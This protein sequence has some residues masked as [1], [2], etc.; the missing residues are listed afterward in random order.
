MTAHDTAEGAHPVLL[1][2]K[3]LER[4]A[5]VVGAYALDAPG[6]RILDLAGCR[7]RLAHLLRKRFPDST[8]TA[9][10]L[11]A[12]VQ[13]LT[14]P[15][16]LIV[17]SALLEGLSVRAPQLRQGAS[18]LAEGG[19]MLCLDPNPA[20]FA[21]RLYPALPARADDPRPV[22]AGS[23]LAVESHV[24]SGFDPAGE[25][26][27]FASRLC[28]ALDRAL[29][30]DTMLGERFGSLRLTVGRRGGAPVPAACPSCRRHGCPP[31]FLAFPF[32]FHLCKAC[33]T[34]FAVRLPGTRDNHSRYHGDWDADLYVDYYEALRRDHARRILEELDAL[35]GERTLLDIG[36]GYGYFVDEARRAGYRARGIDPGL[37]ACIDPDLDG[38]V[39]RVGVEDF[40]QDR[41]N[42]RYR[43]ISML[44]VLEH[45]PDPAPF[46]RQA[47][48]IATP[49]SVVVVSVPTTN[50]FSIYWL[51][52]TLH[53]LTLGVVGKPLFT[54][55]QWG[56]A[57]P[58]VYL[59]SRLGMAEL[60]A[61]EMD[62]RVEAEHPQPIASMANIHKR[63]AMERKRVGLG[64]VG[65]FV[66]LA[67]G[68]A[69]SLYDRLM[70]LFG[71]PNEAVYIIRP[72]ALPKR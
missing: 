5:D 47:G 35:P 31:V 24:L 17:C 37:P 66:M 4:L 30:K 71:L 32:R 29:F 38:H 8:V 50:A 28:A 25:G 3:G 70:G 26:A 42:G 41:E 7:G 67:G 16:D 9:A 49:E 52:F 45:V 22:L 33:G 57:A 12:G 14:G 63:V 53:R 59:P 6:F 10:S 36:C 15:F 20:G 65:A 1:S 51:C 27:T 46:L 69:F 44:G 54:I 55:L 72:R 18:L 43:V 60:F 13:D 21:A 61:R 62:A 2:E 19:V 39:D 48:R 11:G 23:G 68:L 34:W 58:H 56:T 64:P 40:A